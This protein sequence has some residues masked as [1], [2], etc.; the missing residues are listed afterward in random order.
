MASARVL[1]VLA[2]IGCG[3]AS[4]TRHVLFESAQEGHRLRAGVLELDWRRRMVEIQGLDYRPI[5][6]GTPVYDAI[7]DR[8]YVGSPDNAL[9]ALRGR[10]GALLWRFQTLGRVDS[11]PTL[12]GDDLFFGT[13]DGAIYAVDAATGQLRWRVATA[14]QIRRPPVVS[15]D[16]VVFVNANDTVIALARADGTQRWRYRRNAPGGIT[17]AGHA[18]VARSGARLY[19]AFADGNVVCL[20]SRDGSVIWEQDTSAD[21]ENVDESNEAHQPIDVDTTPLVLGDTI[22]VASFSAG[23]YALDAIGGGQRWRLADVTGVAALGTDGRHLYAASANA[24]LVKIDPFDGSVVWARDLRSRAISG[25]LALWNDFLAVPTADDGLWIVRASDG[26]PIDGITPGP[27]FAALPE[28][29]GNRLFIES[30]AGVL[31]AFRMPR[32]VTPR[33]NP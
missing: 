32:P 23:V 9:F 3:C 21:I 13:D 7:H 4:L 10:D 33:P 19:T 1:G 18:G 25:A 6:H 22:Y 26:E 24:G 12:D 30:N 27:G 15:G 8:L 29:S 2:L 16:A 14:A 31:Y 20:D 5:F 11:T 28:F 17:L